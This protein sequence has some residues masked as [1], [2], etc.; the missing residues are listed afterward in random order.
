MPCHANLKNDAMIALAAEF[1]FRLSSSKWNFGRSN[2]FVF[3]PRKCNTPFGVL[4]GPSTDNETGQKCISMYRSTSASRCFL[5]LSLSLSINVANPVRSSFDSIFRTPSKW[6]RLV[7]SL[8]LWS[9]QQDIR[10][11]C[12]AGC[13]SKTKKVFDKKTKGK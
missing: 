12:A 8:V 5:F 2:V 9:Q 1:I 11:R 10:F 7:C 13:N 4:V 6:L 3:P